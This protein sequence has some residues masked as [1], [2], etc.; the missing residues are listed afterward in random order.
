M[1]INELVA[2]STSLANPY[3]V[4]RGSIRDRATMLDIW[5]GRLGD[6]S[7][8]P[9]KFQWFYADSAAGEPLVCLLRHVPS[10]THVGVASAGPRRMLYQGREISAGVLVDFAVIDAHR[11]LGPALTLAKGV[12]DC[13]GSR[14]DLLYG[15]PNL[16][17]EAMTRRAGHYRMA[18]MCRFVCVLR[19]AKYLSSW[20]PRTLAAV[21]AVPVDAARRWSRQLHGRRNAAVLASW[22]EQADARYDSL[23]RQSERGTSLVQV[24]DAAMARWRFDACPLL[25]TRYL[26]LSSRDTGDLL[27]WFACHEQDTT[28]HVDDAWS[29]DGVRG[30]SGACVRRLLLAAWSAGHH[31]VSFSFAGSPQAMLGWTANGFVKRDQR[32]VLGRWVDGQ[33]GAPQDL[34]LTAAD[35]DQ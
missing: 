12:I 25:Q 16:K 24:R 9:H 3:S 17:A 4:E 27:A 11:S 7:T 33:D 13:A 29:I 2:M 1:R 5:H 15:F 8:F 10:N 14:Y 22:A 21:L 6:A 31:A 19:H 30:A 28:L 35:E 23:W 26:L 18:A 34:F 32:P 20:M